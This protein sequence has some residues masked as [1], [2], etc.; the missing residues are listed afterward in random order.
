M[1]RV[2]SLFILSCLFAGLA[3]CASNQ[4]A[5]YRPAVPVKP[6]RSTVFNT[7]TH[8]Q[9]AQYTGQAYTP[10]NQTWYY[11]RKDQTPTVYNGYVTNRSEI[12]ITV[13]RDNNSRNRD[14]YNHSSYTRRKQTINW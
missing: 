14:D 7:P 12:H 3:G 13:T 8:Q 6:L 1:L 11:N 10:A 2:M 4:T 9:L 5:R